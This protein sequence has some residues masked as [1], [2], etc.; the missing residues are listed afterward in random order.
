M[1]VMLTSQDGYYSIA[2]EVRGSTFYIRDLGEHFDEYL[3]RVQ[4]VQRASG[5]ED[6]A[7]DGLDPQALVQR[8]VEM[9]ADLAAVKRVRHQL[10]QIV[11]WALGLCVVRWN[12]PGTDCT[13]E[14]VRLLP[15]RVKS[16]LMN[17]ILQES[18]IT[19]GEAGFPHG[20]GPFNLPR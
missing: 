16:E 8:L 5:V 10:E 12:V 13:P 3:D 17:H 11:D 14:T 20:D 4:Q 19:L 2:V 7:R 9:T 18:Q 1:P 6:L 15:P